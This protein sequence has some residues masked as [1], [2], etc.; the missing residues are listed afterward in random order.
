[1]FLQFFV[2]GAWY[3]TAGTFVPAMGWEQSTTGWVYSAGPI[4]A[5]ISPLF[6]GLIAD[7]FFAS[8][9][10]LAVMHL[11]GAVIMLVLIPGAIEANDATS[12]EWY[13]LAYMLCYMPT[14]GLAN[15]VAFANVSDSSA[16]PKIRVWGTIGW[17]AAGLVNGF[18][19]WSASLNMFY[20]AGI[21][22]LA[23]GV[24]SFFLP[25]TPPN[26]QRSTHPP[27]HDPHH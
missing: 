6:L 23:L 2:W 14:L 25:H 22:A 12:F 24:F 17:I 10:V 19:G 16:F 18:M 21:P 7:R 13:V 1:M 8:Q 4:A 20:T 27:H 5:M 3:V 9:L 26:L 15:S 11:F